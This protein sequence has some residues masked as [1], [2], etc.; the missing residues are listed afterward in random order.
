LKV[1]LNTITHLSFIFCQKYLEYHLLVLWTCFSLISKS[2]WSIS[3]N[4]LILK[5]IGQIHYDFT[6]KINDVRFEDL[7]MHYPS[8]SYQTHCNT[9]DNVCLDLKHCHY[10][11]Y[12]HLIFQKKKNWIVKFYCQLSSKTQF[13]HHGNWTKKITLKVSFQ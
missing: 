7:G 11:I 9:S 13:D 5:I 2:D 8:S 10:S 3:T 6:D 12:I 1:E 4:S